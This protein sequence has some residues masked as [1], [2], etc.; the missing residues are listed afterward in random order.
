MSSIKTIS[1]YVHNMILTSEYNVKGLFFAVNVEIPDSLIDIFE[2]CK[3]VYKNLIKERTG[4][5]GIYT[6]NN[7]ATLIFG[8]IEQ[9]FDSKKFYMKGNHHKIISEIIFI[10]NN[11]LENN[12][13]ITT[14]IVEFYKQLDL[15]MYLMFK[16]YTNHNKTLMMLNQKAITNEIINTY[17]REEVLDILSTYNISINNLSSHQLYG[18]LFKIKMYKNQPRV[19]LISE[20]IDARDNDKYLSFIFE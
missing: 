6:Y 19:S 15:I 11:L 12:Y 20:Y 2:K 18:T 3:E 13:K 17:T 1:N 9:P 16:V 10:F 8:S 7:Q 4:I 5:L 14:S